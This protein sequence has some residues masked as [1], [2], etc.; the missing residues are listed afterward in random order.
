MN[1]DDELQQ[2]L[3][4]IKQICDIC[5]E[6]LVQNGWR[7]D[8]GKDIRVN[9]NNKFTIKMLAFAK[10]LSNNWFFMYVK[11]FTETFHFGSNHLKPHTW[12]L[13]Q[14]YICFI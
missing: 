13:F 2:L 10:V 12:L 4:N 3:I 6:Q 1:E 11:Q 5:Q 7:K 14:V 9:P 8:D